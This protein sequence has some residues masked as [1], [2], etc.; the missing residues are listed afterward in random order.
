MNAIHYLPL[1]CLPVLL[2]L[3]IWRVIA[4]WT[5][6]Q[7]LGSVPGPV[8]PTPAPPL[9]S[10]TADNRHAASWRRERDVSGY[11]KNLEG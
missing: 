10:E 2:A 8:H 5:G 3:V 11:L 7:R 6:R 9:A 1:L 4:Y